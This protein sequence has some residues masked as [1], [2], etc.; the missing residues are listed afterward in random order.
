M[1]DVLTAINFCQ[2]RFESKSEYKANTK[3]AGTVEEVSNC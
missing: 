2:K 1:P 3:L